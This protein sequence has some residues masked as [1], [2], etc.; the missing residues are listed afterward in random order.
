MQWRYAHKA[1][2]WLD[3]TLGSFCW[4]FIGKA[5]TILTRIIA[6]CHAGCSDAIAAPHMSHAAKSNDERQYI[7]QQGDMILE[8]SGTACTAA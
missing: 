5:L 4:V 1:V 8:S 3:S 2:V 7:G 6:L